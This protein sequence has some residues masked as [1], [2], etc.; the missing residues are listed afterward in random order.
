MTNILQF[1]QADHS[2]LTKHEAVLLAQYQQHQDKNLNLDLTRGKPSAQQL[3]IS[4]KLDGILNGNYYSQNG[5]DVRNYGGLDGI[6]EARDLGA[7]ILDLAPSQ[8]LAG[9]NSS[10]TLMYYAV[11][12]SWLY[13]P[14]EGETPWRLE[15]GIK[16]ICPV[17][18]YDRHFTICEEFDIEMIIV[19]MTD[20]GPDM[21]QVEALIK[22]DN[23]IKGIWCVPKYSNPTG[24]VYS[25]EVMD[26]IAQLGKIAPSNFR[27]FMDNAYVVH[28]LVD[29]PPNLASIMSCCQKYG[30]E[31]SVIQ[32][33]STSKISFAGAGIAFLGASKVN[34]QLFK[35]H[36]G[37][38][39][40]GPDKVNQLRH[41]RMFP[42]LNTLKI[43]MHKHAELLR[44]RFDMVLKHLTNNFM[45]NKICEWNEA[46]GGYFI[47]FNTR[48]GLAKAVVKLASEAGVKLTPA[49]ATFPYG[50]DPEDKNIRIAPSVPTIEEVD[51]AMQ[52]FVICVQLATVRQLLSK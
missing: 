37:G 6:A 29:N 32:F 41:C 7:A 47:S 2:E 27:V 49:G 38:L 31:D 17:P 30:T 25:D 36:L 51:G 5:T 35:K 34:L 1:D 12:F 4:N 23:S 3:T 26:R 13:G 40:I 33:T 19:P 28:D 39:S 8:V 48:P 46:Q 14:A 21:D 11:L 50:D 43:Q 45:D 22:A 42:D 16:F 10:L 24:V 20:A 9:G 52:V 44:P 15:P 18:G